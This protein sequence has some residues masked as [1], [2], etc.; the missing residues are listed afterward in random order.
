[1][2]KETTSIAR[3]SKKLVHESN[4]HAPAFLLFMG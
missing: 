2:L 1:M 3:N 4:I